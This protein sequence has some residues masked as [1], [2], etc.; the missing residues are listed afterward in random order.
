MP[1]VTK[2]FLNSIQA[3]DAQYQQ[4]IDTLTY[5][6]SITVEQKFYEVAIAD[7]VPVEVGN[8]SFSESILR[9][10]SFDVAGDFE[11]GIINTGEKS[12][13]A[14]VDAVLSPVTIPVLNWGKYAAYT[15]FD[16]EQAARSSNWDVIE[17]KLKARKK[18]WDLGIQ[19]VAF[20]GSSV[21]SSVTGLLN[22]ANATINTTTI[23]KRISDMSDSEFQTFVGLL[24]ADY[25]TNVNG[26]AM[27]NRFVIPESD[28]VGLGSAASTAYPLITKLEYLENT[29]TR[30]AGKLGASDFKI[31]PSKYGESA[32]SG[33]GVD[34][35]VLYNQN[36]ETMTMHIPVDYTTTNFDTDNQFSFQNVAYGQYT[37][38]GL[39]REREALYFDF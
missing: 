27:A 14:E 1:N 5:I 8:G 16:V 13:L 6:E 26:S 24:L 30:M 9:N 19:K 37:G 10:L 39:Y 36:S 23:T 35:Y 2:T 4:I 11:D 15:L 38:L 17:G 3:K 34:R 29:F 20:L 25:R 33:L 12:R 18:N 31:L 21:I 28:Y 22:N 32:I 7:Y